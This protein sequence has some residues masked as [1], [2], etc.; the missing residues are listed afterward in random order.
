MHAFQPRLPALAEDSGG[1]L[2]VGS[3]RVTLDSVLIAFDRG[4]TP[5][6]IAHRYPALDIASIYEVTGYVLRNRPAFDEYLARRYEEAEKTKAEIERRFPPDGIRQ[7]LIAR[8]A[9]SASR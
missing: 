1:V 7:R 2:R 9:G 6:E 5:E 8:R 3:T 4:A